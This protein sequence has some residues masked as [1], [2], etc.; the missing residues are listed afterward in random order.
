[1]LPVLTAAQMRA[2]DRHTIEV[3]G[4]KGERLM[5]AAGSAVARL[6]A[7]EFGD[8]R[9]AVL[10]GKGN[11]GGDGF[12][13]ARR[14]LGRRPL[15]RRPLV[16]LFGRESEVQGDARTH[17][18]K[19]KTSGGE[20][21]EVADL[22]AWEA[23]KGEVLGCGVLVDALL[24]TGLRSAPSGLVGRVISDLEQSA[25]RP[26]IVAV[27]LPSGLSSDD[28]ALEW[29]ALS[30]VVSVAFAAP[31]R[32]HVLPPACDRVGRLVVADIG[33]PPEV[34]ASAAHVWLLERSDAALA[35]PERS[36]AGHKGSYGHLLV[37]AGSVGKTGAAA[38]AAHA[39]LR[40]GV[41]L[42]TAATPAEAL[43]L[44]VSQ[45][46]P[47]VMTEPLPDGWTKAGLE[48]ALDLAEGRD[49]VV[50]G[51][52]LGRP[53]AASAFVHA[54]LERCTR[55]VVVDADALNA[56][57]QHGTPPARAAA[58]ILTPHPGEMARLVGGDT[59]EVLGRRL[60]LAAELASRA[61]VHVVLKGQRT[62]VAAPEG[63]V[64]VNPTGNPGLATAGTGDVL[65]GVVGALLARGSSAWEAATAGVYLHGLAGDLAARRLGEESLMAG[66]VLAA[67]PDAVRLLREPE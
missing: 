67:L 21:R 62:L 9:P 61:A 19:L 33:I 54:F 57:A 23:V 58:T 4:I 42:V 8:A 38:L 56:L 24:G 60:E 40:A 27:D 52:G 32:G 26:P 47:E 29:P 12:V 64:A 46:R 36:A 48:R 31:K 7:D 50:L 43:P 13:A 2:A 35:Y 34:C 51:P 63:R 10:C 1:M 17:M 5:E 44:L 45:A 59:S 66:D 65:S 14:L 30:A 16:L 3:L 6:L 37:L 39:A 11:N 22:P 18:F 49:A 20:V 15:S 28:G 25:S 55:P 53:E 41:G